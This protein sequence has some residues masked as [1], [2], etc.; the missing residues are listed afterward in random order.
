[1]NGIFLLVIR[2]IFVRLGEA[3]S[4][5]YK[6]NPTEVV[7]ED[8]WLLKIATA[9]CAR[10]SYINYEGNDD[11]HADFELHDRLADMG[12]WSP[13]E[14]CARAM[15]DE[16]FD[17]CTITEP[18]TDRDGNAVLNPIVLGVSG[19]LQ[20]FHQYRKTFKGENVTK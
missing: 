20:G 16:E 12:H 9:R 5:Y 14:H 15:T 11:Y 10:V 7:D 19:N 3:T 17:L 4:D 2:L 6:N 8:K 1:M 18:G 13:F